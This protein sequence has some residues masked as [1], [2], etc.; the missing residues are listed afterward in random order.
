MADRPLQLLHHQPDVKQQRE[1]DHGYEDAQRCGGTGA[2]IGGL[3]DRRALLEGA[4]VIAGA[5]GMGAMVSAAPAAAASAFDAKADA[6]RIAVD[7][8]G[9]GETVLLISGFPQT[10]R[11]WNKIVPLLSKDFRTVTADLPSLGI[12]K[13]SQ[14]RRRQK[15]PGKSSTNSS[16]AS[17]RRCTS[18]RTT[19][20]PG[21]PIAGR[22][23]FRTISSR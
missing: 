18:W 7:R 5:L 20:A 3:L 15:M 14:R 11:S 2:S 12:Q 23:C 6:K 9:S 17:A 10:R 13:S 1:Q 21:S 4:G 16:R 22:C 19:S 8:T